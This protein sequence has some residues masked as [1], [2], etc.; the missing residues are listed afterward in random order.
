MFLA[1]LKDISVFETCFGE[2]NDE[3]KSLDKQADNSTLAQ[4]SLKYETKVPQLEYMCLMMENM[5]MT[6]KLN[7][8]I[9]AGFQKQSRAT[10]IMDRYLAMAEYCNIYL[11]G[12]ND[13]DLPEHPN[14][15]YIDLPPQANLM[16]E[17]FLVI[18]G[19]AFKSMMVAYDLDG[20]GNHAVEE[21]RNFKGVKSSSPEVINQ[22]KGLLSS[23]I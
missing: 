1:K 6:K 14:I 19:D 9:Y 15:T 21:D 20:F 23:V 11:F 22:A 17:W 12:E 16:R 7:G 5:V 4:S 8:T 13:V 18:D 3:V 2:V 10:A